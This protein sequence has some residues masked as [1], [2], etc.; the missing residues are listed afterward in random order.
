MIQCRICLEE[1]LNRED[2]IVP[3]NCRGTQKYVHKYCLNAWRTVNRRNRLYHTC[4][5]CERNY[6]FT[7]IL[8]LN[9]IP[10]YTGEYQTTDEVNKPYR[11]LS[12]TMYYL[13]GNPIMNMFLIQFIS[14]VVELSSNP[15]DNTMIEE[16]A[17]INP[18]YRE[19][20]SHIYYMLTVLTLEF[21]LSLYYIV[22]VLRLFKCCE[23]MR[24]FIKTNDTNNA[25]F[26]IMIFLMISA[27]YAPVFS[28]I[29]FSIAY[30]S[31]LENHRNVI[32]T[33]NRNKIMNTIIDVEDIER[34]LEQPLLHQ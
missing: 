5:I 19:H 33:M 27:G 13:F 17:K 25:S 10:V 32:I 28:S 30:S 23:Y 2:V 34:G 6:S 12:N 11:I 16:F 1:N 15:T 9:Y 21:F 7:R 20:P 29:I 3:C 24:E 18:Y 22:D 14:G 8:G 26:I 4:R 31:L